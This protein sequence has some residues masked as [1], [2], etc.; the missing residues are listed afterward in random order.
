MARYDFLLFEGMTRFF[1]GG[2]A[3]LCTASSGRLIEV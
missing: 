1:D 2:L 3:T